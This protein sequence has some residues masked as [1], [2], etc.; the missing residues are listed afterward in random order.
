M[1]ILISIFL[2]TQIAFS[3]AAAQGNVLTADDI[4]KLLDD[5]TDK[6]DKEDS[7]REEK[8]EAKKDVDE[9][10]KNIDLSSLKS[11]QAFDDIAVIQRRFLPKSQRME[12][13]A[14]LGA[15][16][17]DAFFL[18]LGFQGRLAYHFSESM[19][20]EIVGIMLSNSKR[21][22]TNDL[23]NNKGVKTTSLVTPESYYGLDFSWTPIYG[24]MAFL[25]DNIVPFDLYFSMGGGL[26]NTNQKESEGT[27]HIGVG[28]KFAISKAFAFRWDLSWNF[29][30]A[31][32]KDPNKTTNQLESSS[33]D[34]LFITAGL[35]YYFPE[36]SYR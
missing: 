17:N 34:N 2:I 13:F 30:S 4:E 20:L 8:R 5:E 16:V 35:S 12:F 10:D 11:L 36:A 21:D 6:S 24:K 26:T 19:G 27:V 32:F 23:L 14:G 28:Q 31:K 18:N 29:F 33:F 25:D 1:K 9:D 3:R 15:Q 7:R 22:V